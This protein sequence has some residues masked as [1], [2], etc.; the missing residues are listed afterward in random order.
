MATRVQHILLLLYGKWLTLLAIQ[1][2]SQSAIELSM[3]YHSVGFL[4][5]VSRY[6]GVLEGI[7]KL[8]HF[9]SSHT[10][11]HRNRGGGYIFRFLWTYLRSYRERE[12]SLVVRLLYKVSDWVGVFIELLLM[13][14]KS[15]FFY[16]GFTCTRLSKGWGS[17][18]MSSLPVSSNLEVLLVW[19]GANRIFILAGYE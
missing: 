12:T 19:S 1:D 9:C 14:E 8:D 4:P 17:T 13:K 3:I 16:I 5:W 2:K 7:E 11:L 10:N 18:R 6:S 15:R